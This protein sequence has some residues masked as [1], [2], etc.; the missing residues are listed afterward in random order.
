MK[1]KSYSESSLASSSAGKGRSREKSA[2]NPHL[3]IQRSL[4]A[5]QLPNGILQYVDGRTGMKQD[6]QHQTEHQIE[7]LDSD[8]F[9]KK[10]W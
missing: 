4:T 9:K 3:G 10:I 2:S 6:M 8:H 5:S 7:Q 1:H